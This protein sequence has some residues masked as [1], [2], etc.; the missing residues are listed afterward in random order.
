[1]SNNTDFIIIRKKKPV[2]KP[3][4]KPY[5][6]M[7]W[8]ELQANIQPDEK[9][10]CYNSKDRDDYAK[11]YGEN[12]DKGKWYDEGC[13]ELEQDAKWLEDCKYQTRFGNPKLIDMYNI[14][15]IDR[16]FVRMKRLQNPRFKHTKREDAYLIELE[17]RVY[18]NI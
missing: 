10:V 13:E 11:S 7:D 15:K 3:V 12:P 18:Q 4:E 16:H 17:K 8:E 5:H 1:M 6:L 14:A 9:P 2:K